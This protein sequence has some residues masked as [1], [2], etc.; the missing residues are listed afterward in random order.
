MLSRLR[1]L[2]WT[3]IGKRQIRQAIE[4]SSA[5]GSVKVV[6]GASITRFEGWISTD[7]PHFN[8]LRAADWK[9]AFG[10]VRA[11]NLLAEHVFE[12]LSEEQVRTGIRF[13]FQY[14][15][16][17][18]RL[19]I[20]VPDANHPNP[21]YLK[22]VL[23]PADDHRSSWTFEKL[24][25]LLVSCGF[26]VEPLEY[27]SAGHVLTALPIAPAGGPVSRSVQRKD[28]VPLIEGYSSLIVDAIKP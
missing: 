14:L 1:K 12:H 17:G 8:I 27:Y 28:I 15:K 21:A 3:L 20:A 22:M 5:Q 4:R 18:G 11:D 19:R 24:S 10:A 13:C 23:P 25:Q 6:L 9:R 26:R 16:P 7:L 2:R